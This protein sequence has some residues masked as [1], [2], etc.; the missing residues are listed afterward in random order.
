[1]AI[2][3]VTELVKQIAVVDLRAILEQSGYSGFAID[4]AEYAGQGDDERYAGVFVCTAADDS[5]TEPDGI[6]RFHLYLQTLENGEFI[7]DF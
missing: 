1:M 6:V 5:G 7:A 2:T 4:T 3:N